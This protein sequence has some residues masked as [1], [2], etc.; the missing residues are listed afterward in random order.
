MEPVYKRVGME[1]AT[2][3]QLVEYLTTHDIAIDPA[4]KESREALL[5]LVDLAK[6]P[7]DYIF[8]ETVPEQVDGPARRMEDP[9]SSPYNGDESA[10]RWVMLRIQPDG[11]G[12]TQRAQNNLVPVGVNGNMVHLL[13]NRP[14]VIRERFFYQIQNSTMR[15]RDQSFNEDGTPT[16]KF[17][18]AVVTVV[19]RYPYTFLGFKGRVKDGPPV[20]YDGSAMKDQV[21]VYA[22]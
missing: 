10:E 16:S 12:D 8:V 22:A 19:E 1:D 17:E 14:I 3:E 21:K 13:R 9:Y 20:E 7:N 11:R 5:A 4:D 2:N 18:D 6:L 15:K